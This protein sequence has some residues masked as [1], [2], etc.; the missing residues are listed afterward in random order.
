MLDGLRMRLAAGEQPGQ[1]VAAL[2]VALHLLQSS[3]GL[4]LLAR[5]HAV[6]LLDSV[7]G[8]LPGPACAAALQSAELREQV[9]DAALT[10]LAT[11]CHTAA[12]AAG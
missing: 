8:A 1:V 2:R 9:A 4:Q 3:P 5:H 11:C 10:F 12:T 6:S 7:L